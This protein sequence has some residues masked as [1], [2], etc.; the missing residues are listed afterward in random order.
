MSFTPR[1]RLG[2][3]LAA[4]AMVMTA[5]GSAAPAAA[6]V[7]YGPI[8]PNI[9][10]SN[11]GG[12]VALSGDYTKIVGSWTEPQVTCN[13][14]SNLFAPWVGIDGDGSQ[15]VEQTGVQT[16]CSSGSPVMSPWYEMYPAAPVYWSETIKVGDKIT[17]KVIANGS[18]YT[19]TLTDTTQGW[20]KTF[21]KTGNDSDVSAEAVIESPPSSYPTFSKLT[22]TG[23]RVNGQVLSSYGPT[24]YASGQYT[25]TALKN[26][27]FS[28]V[29]ASG[30][31]RGSVR[32][33]PSYLRS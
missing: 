16:D 17:G 23:V 29:P 11:W 3:A 2:L 22:F 15:T 4:G 21:H 1:P 9:Q 7:S 32:E 8:R 25:P 26:G 13:S 18:N 24:A 30:G 27:T 31:H 14:D 6:S 33:L 10:T 5:L 12:Y 19:L 28:M 20:T